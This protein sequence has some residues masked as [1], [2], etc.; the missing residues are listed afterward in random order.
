M[1]VYQSRRSRL[2]ADLVSA[3]WTEGEASAVVREWEFEANRRGVDQRSTGF[4]TEGRAWITERRSHE[5]T[6]SEPTQRL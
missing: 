5:G 4:W 2:I 3:G 6:D 1:S